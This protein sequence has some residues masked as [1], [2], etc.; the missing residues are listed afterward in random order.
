MLISSKAAQN[1]VNNIRIIWNTYFSVYQAINFILIYKKWKHYINIRMHTCI[2]ID[3]H[4]RMHTYID[5]RTDA[6]IHIYINT[7]T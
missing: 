3:T 2:D 7:R 4:G 6:Y 1:I 5:T